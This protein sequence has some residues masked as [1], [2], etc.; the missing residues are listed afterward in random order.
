M[1]CRMGLELGAGGNTKQAHQAVSLVS[2]LILVTDSTL[3]LISYVCI[4]EIKIFQ[5][6]KGKQNVRLHAI[7]RSG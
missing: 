1:L 3:Y 2:I 6:G 5:V 4:L 7:Y